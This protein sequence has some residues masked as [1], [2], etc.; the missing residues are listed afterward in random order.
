LQLFNF[1]SQRP[2]IREGSAKSLVLRILATVPLQ[3]AQHVQQFLEFHIE[4]VR[5]HARGLLEVTPSVPASAEHPFHDVALVLIHSHDIL[6]DRGLDSPL[7]C[8]HTTTCMEGYS[9]RESI[10][11]RGEENPTGWVVITSVLFSGTL[12]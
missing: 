9:G 3:T 12:C 8:L 4:A 2:L 1:P 6:P 7:C 11:T 5:D 10:L